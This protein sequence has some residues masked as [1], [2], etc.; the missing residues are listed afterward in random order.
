VLI[1][2]FLE[3]EE[4]SLLA[5]CDGERAVPMAP[6]QDFKRIGE[7]DTG[8][9]TGGMGSY[10]P[11]PGIGA[12]QA[13]E[14]TR[15]VHQPVVD[16]LRSRGVP[17]RGVLYA[18]LMLTAAGPQ[19]LEFNCRFGDPE[20]QAVLPRLRS[21]LIDVVEAC[22]APGGLAG[23]ALQWSPEWAVTV[24]MASAGYPASARKGDVITGLAQA[25]EVEI[26]HAGTAEQDGQLVT[27][28]GRVLNVTGLGPTLEDARGRAYAAVE[29]I[30]FDG[31]QYRSDIA[32]RVAERV[33][34]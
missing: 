31:A 21:D 1:E 32:A 29:R 5:L 34:I 8:P 28:G 12:E 22:L 25:E 7:G 18:G 9:N 33:A 24:V 11:V 6:A 23:M 27:A 3:G 14:I 30:H 19:V 10:S 4:L 20:T 26:T 15:T 2:E 16:A 17:F 13:A